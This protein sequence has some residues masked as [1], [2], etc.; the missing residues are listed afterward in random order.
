MCFRLPGMTLESATRTLDAHLQSRGVRRPE[1]TSTSGANGT[2]V[3]GP[4]GERLE[5]VIAGDGPFATT[6]TCRIM[7]AR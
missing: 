6:G 7:P 4:A 5:I 1:W 3:L 2:F